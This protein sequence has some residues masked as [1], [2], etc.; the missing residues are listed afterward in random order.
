MN[1]PP[2]PPRQAVLHYGTPDF[3]VVQ[4]GDFVLCA[5]S[6][7]AIPLDALTYWN[8]AL[9]EAYASAEFMTRRWVETH[10]AET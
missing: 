8:V 10:K 9:Q 5:V 7:A 3:E 1:P 2:A 6:G 4:P